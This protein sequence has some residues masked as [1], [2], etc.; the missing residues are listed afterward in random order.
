MLR[1]RATVYRGEASLSDAGRATLS[2]AGDPIAEDVPCSLQP[3]QAPS[4][5]GKVGRFPLVG[6]FAFWCRFG[7]DL[8]QGDRVVVGSTAYEV[9]SVDDSAGRGAVLMAGLDLDRGRDG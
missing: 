9:R 6:A 2:F 1:Q 7:L 4:A 5:A 8:K 3:N